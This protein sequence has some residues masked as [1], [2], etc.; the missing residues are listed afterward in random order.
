MS[1]SIREE[2]FLGTKKHLVGILKVIIDSKIMVLKKVLLFKS[3]LGVLLPKHLSQ[4]LNLSQGDYVEVYLNNNSELII[5]KHNIDIKP[6]RDIE[7][8]EV[9][10]NE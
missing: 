9:S 2:C 4:A 6:I 8:K 7:Q 3:V 5:R 10:I 1:F